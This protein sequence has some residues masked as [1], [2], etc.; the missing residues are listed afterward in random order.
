M[1][2]IV[3]VD[4]N[5]G[6][7]RNGKLL[8]SIPEDMQRFK[9]TTLNKV[10][11]MGRKTFE[12]LPNGKGLSNR[13]NIVLTK[14]NSFK[15]ENVITV[16]SLSEAL[17]KI[18]KY[19]PDDVFII[20]GGEIYKVFLEYCDEAIVTKVRA[21]RQADSFFPNLDNHKN[22]AKTS[23]SEVK[24]YDGIEFAFVKYINERFL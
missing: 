2:A 6:I 19:P 7:G 10:V 1:K 11:V 18:K 14:D 5:W 16:S 9:E 13:V 12:S 4:N 21:E 15:A 24:T 22:W 3:A 23:E 8:F 20:G 17:N